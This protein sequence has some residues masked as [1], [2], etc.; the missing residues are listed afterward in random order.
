MSL[1]KF[2]ESRKNIMKYLGS[3]E[4]GALDKEPN[5]YFGMFVCAEIFGKLYFDFNAFEA[6]YTPKEVA[7]LFI[8]NTDV[9]HDV[10]ENWDG[11]VCK[12]KVKSSETYEI[13]V[14]DLDSYKDL[15]EEMISYVA[16]NSSYCVITLPP[17]GMGEASYAVIPKAIEADTNILIENFLPVD[18]LIRVAEAG[19]EEGLNAL[20]QCSPD[21]DKYANELSDSGDRPIFA[22][23][24]TKDLGFVKIAMELSSP[25][26]KNDKGVTA[27]KYAEDYFSD[28]EVNEL[29][30]EWEPNDWPNV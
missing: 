11:E 15:R 5:E 10:T 8:E 9:D 14:K 7:T 29:F 23:I 17:V 21:P 20:L 2:E 1:S 18:Y 19:S 13:L 27:V 4:S 6:E 3:S 28:K 24:R 16:K 25:F 30:D 22:A 26:L 12:V